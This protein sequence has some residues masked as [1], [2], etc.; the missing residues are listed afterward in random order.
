MTDFNK[1]H[2][3]VEIKD[4]TSFFLRRL[5]D[6]SKYVNDGGDEEFVNKVNAVKVACEELLAMSCEIANVE[7]P[8]ERIVIDADRGINDFL[9]GCGSCSGDC[10]CDGD[11]SGGCGGCGGNP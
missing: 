11:C 4:I 10:D 1:Y 5:K 8:P 2:S 6:V 7:R 9:E 3:A